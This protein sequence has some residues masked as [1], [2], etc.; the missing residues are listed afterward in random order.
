MSV[1]NTI[2]YITEENINDKDILFHD[3]YSNEDSNYY[4]SDDFSK[5]FYIH[6]ACCGFISTSTINEDKLYLLPEMQFEYSILDFKNLH[7]SKKVKKLLNQDNYKFTINKRF[8]EVLDK[9]ETYHNPNWLI[10]EYKTLAKELSIYKPSWV[11]FELMS[12]EVSNKETN[13][14]IAAEIGYKINNT[15]TSLTGFS[16]KERKYNNYGKLQ[17]VLL[18]QYLEKENFTFWN[19]GHPYMQYKFDL[20][21]IK[22]SRQDFLKRWLPEIGS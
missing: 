16:T 9:I 2:Y 17:L 15:Y 3:I 4:F 8:D 19:L 12:I 5:D 18:A 14:L 1:E 6:L 22:Y 11:D 7:I 10:G 21:A 13:E 20:G